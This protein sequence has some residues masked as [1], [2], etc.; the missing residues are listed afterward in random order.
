MLRKQNHVMTPSVPDTVYLC[1][2]GLSGSHPQIKVGL[3]NM[4]GKG[5]FTVGYMIKELDH[6]TSVTVELDRMEHIELIL[7]VP[8]IAIGKPRKMEMTFFTETIDG[9]QEGQN[10]TVTFLPAGFVDRTKYTADALMMQ[11][12]SER[13]KESGTSG[14][15]LTDMDAAYAELSEYELSDSPPVTERIIAVAPP[16]DIE[17]YGEGSEMELS[18]LYM[19]MMFSKGYDMA[20]FIAPDGKVFTGAVTEDKDGTFMSVADGSEGS[21]IFVRPSDSSRSIPFSVSLE[22]SFGNVNP[23]YRTAV[24]GK[25][26]SSSKNLSNSFRK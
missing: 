5:E 14:A 26:R 16:M 1:F 2:K 3:D 13:A 17:E 4:S 24:E 22:N 10:R 9:L 7:E 11:S 12:I 21:A 23:M 8:D 19:H 25:S 18:C 20:L 6:R 15:V